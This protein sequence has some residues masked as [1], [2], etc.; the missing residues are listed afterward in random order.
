[1]TADWATLRFFEEAPWPL[2]VILLVLSGAAFVALEHKEWLQKRRWYASTL[3]A[4]TF[5]YLVLCGYGYYALPTH[6]TQAGSV[7]PS[8]PPST[9][10][11]VKG[12]CEFLFAYKQ[13]YIEPESYRATYNLPGTRF[14]IGLKSSIHLSSANPEIL[15]VERFTNGAWE[16]LIFSNAEDKLMWDD[17][18]RMYQPKDISEDNEQQIILFHYF[19]GKLL[20]SNERDA[21]EFSRYKDLKPRAYQLHIRVNDA[22]GRADK[23]RQ[24]V[25][26]EWYGDPETMR[27]ELD[28]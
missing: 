26:V 25:H 3:I 13:P 2:V 27:I 6:G 24:L 12:P 8:T 18:E 22:G 14:S 19:Q 16:P 7:A 1:M 10:P 21:A 23:C 15:S 11:A 20:L 17:L 28:K 9:S 5:A 4:I